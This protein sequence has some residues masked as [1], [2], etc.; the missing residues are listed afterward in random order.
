[1]LTNRDYVSLLQKLL[2][3]HLCPTTKVAVTKPRAE[4]KRLKGHPYPVSE[5]TLLKNLVEVPDDV[6]IQ[7][8]AELDGLNDL[9]DG[10]GD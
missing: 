1:M 5:E 6:I 7:T 4:Y 3:A 2:I 10:D 8:P 9:E